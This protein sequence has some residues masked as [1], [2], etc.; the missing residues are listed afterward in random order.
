[1]RCR[2]Q[3]ACFTFLVGSSLTGKTSR[4]EPACV[5]ETL[6][7]VDQWVRESL[8]S[9]PLQILLDRFRSRTRTRHRLSVLRRLRLARAARGKPI[10]MVL[11]F[12]HMQVKEN[13][14]VRLEVSVFP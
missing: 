3:E 6:N 11:L 8:G 1:M 4:G 9:R 13:Q 2:H 12:L 5:K 10:A 14:I 7:A